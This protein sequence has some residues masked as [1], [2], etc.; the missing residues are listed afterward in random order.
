[1]HGLK[2]GK[3][4]KEMRGH[5]SFVNHVAFTSDGSQVRG[6]PKRRT[7]VWGLAARAWP[8][9]RPLLPPTHPSPYTH[10][11]VRR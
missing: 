11:R 8:A 6:R 5:T 2:S 9:P 1:V 7:A 4:L 3:M 10:A